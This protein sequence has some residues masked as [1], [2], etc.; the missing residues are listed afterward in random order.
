[1]AQDD[2]KLRADII[3]QLEA[4]TCAQPSAF[5]KVDAQGQLRSDLTDCTPEQLEALKE[6]QVVIRQ[7]PGRGSSRETKFGFKMHDIM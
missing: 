3:A 2:E 6:F 7:T 5:L 4:I 1:M